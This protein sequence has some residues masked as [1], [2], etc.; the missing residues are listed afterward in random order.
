MSDNSIVFEKDGG[1]A[2]I[3]LNRPEQRNCVDE[4][5]A[6]GLREALERFENDPGLRI[7]ILT[8]A[9]P[10]F[11]AGMDLT[12][13][14]D[15][16]G[17]KILFGE[18]RLA[19]FVDAPRSKPVIAAVEGAALAGGLEIALACD[20]LVAGESAV[21][22]LPEVGVGIFPVAGGAFRLARRISPAKALELCLTADRLDAQTAHDLGLVNRVAASGEALSEAHRLADSILR[23]APLAVSAAYQIGRAAMLAGEAEFWANSEALWPAVA[24]SADASEG[25]RAF[26]EKRRPV[27]SGR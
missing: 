11:C 23:N 3:T 16:Q 2:I 21:F 9:G 26:K 19:G 24:G 25:P 20:M 10:V 12:A 8:G 22:G 1:I 7:G 13:F 27:W 14:L 18:N 4:G 6:I 15:G 17:D 5:L